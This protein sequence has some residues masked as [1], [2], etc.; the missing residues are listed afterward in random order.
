[1]TNIDLFFLTLFVSELIIVSYGPYASKK[2]WPIGLLFTSTSP[3][4]VIGGIGMF[5]SPIVAFFYIKWYFVII[6]IIGGFVISLI[7]TELLKKNSQ[8][9]SIL[10]FI[11]SWLFLLIKF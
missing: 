11:V 6:G 8:F 10:L 1:M 5:G 7:L 2:G 4:L 9:F 3:L